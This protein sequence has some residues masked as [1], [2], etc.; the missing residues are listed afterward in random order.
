MRVRQKDNFDHGL[1]A[2]KDIAVRFSEVDAMGIVWHGNYLKYFED[3]RD[4]FGSIYDLD[5]VKLYSKEGFLTPL[6]KVDIDYKRTLKLGEKAIIETRFVPTDAAKIIFDYRLVH[7]ETKQVLT[8]G[9]T[10][11]VFV[12]ND[13]LAITVPSFFQEWKDKWLNG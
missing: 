9:R 6:V 2:R 11:Q 8:T 13:E 1:I 10:I 4:E 3:G 12:K 7:Q 5:F